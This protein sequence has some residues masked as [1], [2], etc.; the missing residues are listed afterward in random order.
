[1]CLKNRSFY[2]TVFCTWVVLHWVAGIQRTSPKKQCYTVRYPHA[3][4]F[5]VFRSV[6]THRPTLSRAIDP[7][8]VSSYTPRRPRGPRIQGNHVDLKNIG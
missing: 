8:R 1:M 6:A 2:E 5:P 4:N 7:A 3:I